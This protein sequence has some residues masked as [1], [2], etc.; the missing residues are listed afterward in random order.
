MASSNL[1]CYGV[2]IRIISSFKIYKIWR[3]LNIT[4]SIC[5]IVTNYQNNFLW[6]NW[7]KTKI[8][9][10]ENVL[11]HLFYLVKVVCFFSQS[12]VCILNSL[13]TNNSLRIK[14]CLNFRKFWSKWKKWNEITISWIS[15]KK[16][17]CWIISVSLIFIWLEILI[18]SSF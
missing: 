10:E 3:S 7:L 14:E 16:S 9:I 4:L 8:W 6:I 12:P 17:E 11:Q 13:R 5:N 18:L 15:W 2:R 1:W